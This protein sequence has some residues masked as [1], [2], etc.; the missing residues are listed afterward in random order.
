MRQLIKGEKMNKKT[1]IIIR[2]Q[3]E[4]THQ[5]INAPDAVSMLRS[6]HRHLFYVEVEL[7]VYGDDRELEFILVKRALNDFLDNKPFTITT[8]C[9]QMADAI[10]GFLIEKYGNRNI[11]CCVYEDNENGGCVYYEF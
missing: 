4:G 5:Y 2:T 1:T 9:E 8:S 7:D 6:I 10:C 3:F 11:R